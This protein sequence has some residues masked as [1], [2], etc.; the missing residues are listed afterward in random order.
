[1]GG[2]LSDDGRRPD[3]DEMKKKKMGGT[4]QLKF[5]SSPKR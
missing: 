3:E 2:V 1:M 4:Y 5:S